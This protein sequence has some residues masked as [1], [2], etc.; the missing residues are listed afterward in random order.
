MK[1][2]KTFL[3]I[4][5][6]FLVSCS[7]SSQLSETKQNEDSSE[8][9]QSSTSKPKILGGKLSQLNPVKIGEPIILKFT[10]S[11]NL[12]STASFCKWHTPFEP[13][14]SKYLDVFA[15]DGTEINFTGPMAKRM[16]PPPANSY[17]SLKAK[18][19]T[20]VDFDLT[21][22]YPIKKAGVYIVKY[23]STGISGITFPD[24]L[25]VTV[26]N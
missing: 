13:L 10:V 19:S 18:D 5:S 23:N 15:E 2:I 22:A 6:I 11:N 16:M 8:T 26:G 21:K 14:S 17:V 25:K 7:S 20:S 1:N 3:A 9:S 4:S 12:D 24:S